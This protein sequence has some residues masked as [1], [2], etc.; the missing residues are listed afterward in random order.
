MKKI[1]FVLMVGALALT[2]CRMRTIADLQAEIKTTPTK[3]TVL[4]Y[5]TIYDRAKEI[6]VGE[7]IYDIGSQRSNV[8]VMKLK[9]GYLV[10][11]NGHGA[12]FIPNELY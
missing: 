3:D 6:K 5:P 12:I 1:F 2:S 10:D 7:L 8:S 11:I 9:G 4:I